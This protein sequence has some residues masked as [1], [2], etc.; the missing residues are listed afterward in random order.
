MKIFTKLILISLLFV[1]IYTQS[2]QNQGDSTYYVENGQAYLHI[3]GQGE[4][5]V[6]SHGDRDVNSVTLGN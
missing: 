4:Q 3:Y 2:N 6:D 1:A 5:G